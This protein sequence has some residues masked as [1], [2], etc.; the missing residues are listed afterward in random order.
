M[1]KLR[2]VL[3]FLCIGGIFFLPL[4]FVKADSAVSVTSNVGIS[5]H[6]KNPEVP[7]SSSNSSGN[8]GEVVSHKENDLPALNSARDRSFKFFGVLALM[9]ALFGTLKSR[10]VAN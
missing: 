3:L 6:G 9:L 8:D 5:F 4:N 10:N 2:S 7:N 1:K